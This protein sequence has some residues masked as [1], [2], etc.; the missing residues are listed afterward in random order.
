MRREICR[1]NEKSRAF[2]KGACTL[3]AIDGALMEEGEAILRIGK[4]KSAESGQGVKLERRVCGP[5]DRE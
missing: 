3:I 4:K 1:S 5:G 2:Q